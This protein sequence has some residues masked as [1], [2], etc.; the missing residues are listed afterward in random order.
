MAGALLCVPIEDGARA[1]AC[2]GTDA[3]TGAPD[4]LADAAEAPRFLGSYPPYGCHFFA[5]ALLSV[6]CVLPIV[7]DVDKSESTGALTGAGGARDGT[8]A[9]GGLQVLLARL[10]GSYPVYGPHFFAGAL[11]CVSVEDA[12]R[13]PTCSGADTGTGMPD[14][15]AGATEASRFLGSYPPY[16]SH[17]LVGMLLTGPDE[18]LAVAGQVSRA[19]TA[20]LTDAAGLAGKLAAGVADALRFL[21]SYPQYASHFLAGALLCAAVLVSTLVS[22][23]AGAMLVLSSICDAHPGTYPVGDCHV[24]TSDATASSCR[25]GT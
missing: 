2:S 1:P 5:G 20:A 13:T 4:T 24:R 12:A 9:A 18:V 15:S 6:T 25:L 10:L 16:G 14:A 21:G 19:C 11:L 23:A 3:G 17:F 7:G 8:Y 22:R